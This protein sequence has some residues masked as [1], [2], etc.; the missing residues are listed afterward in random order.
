MSKKLTYEFV[1]EQFEKKNYR[2]LSMEYIDNKSKLEC[3]CPSGHRHSV[4]WRNWQKGV[5]CPI[6]AIKIRA[7]K[8]KKNF[9][10]I[11]KEF[12]NEGYRLL[13]IEYKNSY[14]KL[15]YICPN[16]HKN[17]MPWRNWQQGHRCPYCCGNMKPTIEFIN[18]KFKEEGYILLTTE[19]INSKQKLEYICPNGHKHSITWSKWQQKR[20]CPYCNSK[21]KKDIEFIRSEFAEKGY[22]LLA[23]KYIN[24]T[25][26]LKYICPRGHRHSIAW[27]GWQRGHR[28][29]CFAGRLFIDIN[30]INSEFAKE[31]YQL[32][33]T[34][35]VNAHQKLDYICPKGHKHSITWG[36][37]QQGKRC[38]FC[39]Y[40]RLATIFCGSGASNWKNYSEE[41]LEK[42][43][44][45]KSHVLQLT[46]QNYRK[47]I[48]IINPLNL[49]RSRNEYHLDHIYSVIDGF[50]NN[51]LA[52]IIACPFNLRMLKSTDNLSK[53]GRSDILLKELYNRYNNWRKISNEV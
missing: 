51:I 26:K 32:L 36:H 25:Q 11:K 13:T 8:T 10:I 45:Y 24:N 49:S 40:E 22:K 30:F 46:E 41:D 33:T 39:H 12:E 27:A 28:C 18:L 5:G 3:I 50:K 1:K 9:T 37:W 20:R 21:S 2:L 14:Q 48:D 17:N 7:T 15:E 19:Y 52:E 53:N 6:C 23:K 34:G 31:N 44:S 42:L 47:Y 16:G 43:F 4:I 38:P 29:P 35:Y